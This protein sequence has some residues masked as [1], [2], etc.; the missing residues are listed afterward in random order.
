[1]LG[2]CTHSARLQISQDESADRPRRCSC[3][4]RSVVRRSRCSRASPR[5]PLDERE[6]GRSPRGPASCA[7]LRPLRSAIGRSLDQCC[8]CSAPTGCRSSAGPCPLAVEPSRSIDH[9]IVPAADSAPSEGCGHRGRASSNAARGDQLAPGE[10]DST[11]RNALLM[12][13]IHTSTRGWG[14]PARP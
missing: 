1:M 9:P 13:S 4:R 3:L 10:G 5:R 12:P 7:A 11:R 14:W 8:G 6:A 2:R